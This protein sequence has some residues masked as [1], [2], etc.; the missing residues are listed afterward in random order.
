MF[1]SKVFWSLCLIL[2]VLVTTCK[3]FVTGYATYTE[4]TAKLKPYW[5]KRITYLCTQMHLSGL[6]TVS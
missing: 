4:L 3:Q 5:D 1:L 2:G 6:K